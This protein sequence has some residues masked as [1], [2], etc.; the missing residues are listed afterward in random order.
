MVLGIEYELNDITDGSLDVVRTIGQIAAWSDLN[1][2][3]SGR[4]R[5]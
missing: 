5:I 4:D 1:C 3:N 2:M